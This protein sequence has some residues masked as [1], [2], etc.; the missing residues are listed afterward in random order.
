MDDIKILIIMFKKIAS[1]NV[2]LVS[3]LINVL[4]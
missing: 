2:V 4:V 3:K 1:L